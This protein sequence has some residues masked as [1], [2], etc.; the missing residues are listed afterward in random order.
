VP[1][2]TAEGQHTIDFV[3]ILPEGEAYSIPAS[4]TVLKPDIP[5][6]NARVTSLRFYES[7][8]DT[9]P[10]EEIVY[11]QRFASDTTRYINWVLDL[12][13]PAP[14]QPRALEITAVW[15]QDNGTPSWEEIHRHTLDTSIEGDW[16]WSYHEWGYGC[17]DPVD[18]WEVGS[19]R[20]DIYVAGKMITSAPFEIYAAAL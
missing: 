11:A 1:D 13:H 6:L 16:T 18:C 7:G 17:D 12:E 19:Y 3:G 15:Y 2:D 10:P 14:G 9:V 20:V 5:S 4:L 8:Y